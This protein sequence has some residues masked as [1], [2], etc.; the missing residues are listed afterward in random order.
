MLSVLS[1]LWPALALA[2]DWQDLSDE[3]RRWRMGRA[4]EA[5]G[6][7]PG[8]IQ[9]WGIDLSIIRLIQIIEQTP[10]STDLG[11]FGTS[12]W[13]EGYPYIKEF[14]KALNLVR[15][16]LLFPF[17]FV[18]YTEKGS[19]IKVPAPGWS[20]FKSGDR[21]NPNS[22]PD[23]I[24]PSFE[25]PQD[26]LWI[27]AAGVHPRF[28]SDT[29]Y[30]RCDMNDE[31]NV[32]L[33]T[34]GIR[35][36]VDQLR[37]TKDPPEPR[38]L[39]EGE[40][41]HPDL[42]MAEDRILRGSPSYC[43]RFQANFSCPNIASY[44]KLHPRLLWL[45]LWLHN[46]EPKDVRIQIWLARNLLTV[47]DKQAVKILENQSFRKS[48]YPPDVIDQNGWHTTHSLLQVVQAWRR[49]EEARRGSCQGAVT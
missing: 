5:I 38:L 49:V 8:A 39:K 9:V 43:F 1:L 14:K 35:K 34:V 24:C 48:G 37:K 26:Q 7:I 15:P 21:G 44:L 46:K 17:G 29:A 30:I 36:Y 25:I 47:S 23:G 2:T 41:T 19:R 33:H 10:I 11:D 4:M 3:D 45:P 28:N 6:D 13:E 22:Y 31:V 32:S 40:K 27:L 42:A 18:I 20:K 12:K 16:I